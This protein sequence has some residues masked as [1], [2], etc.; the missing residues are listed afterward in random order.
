MRHLYRVDTPEQ[1]K[2]M[3]P[4]CKEGSVLNVATVWS[5]TR[6]RRGGTCPWDGNIMISFYEKD[7][8]TRAEAF[9]IDTEGEVMPF[10]RLKIVSAL[11]WC[12]ESLV[13]IETPRMAVAEA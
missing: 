7:G 12:K 6:R 9:R 4:F 10:A 3:E 5:A 1:L 2:E 8:K 13:E 11:K